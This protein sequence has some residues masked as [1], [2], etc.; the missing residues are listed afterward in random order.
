MTHKEV[1]LS[2]LDR[3]SEYNPDADLERI[4]AA[5]HFASKVHKDQKRLSGHPFVS[6]ALSVA[7]LVAELKLDEDSIIA[8]LLHDVLDEAEREVQLDEIEEKFGLDTA[9]L[10]DGVSNFRQA[11]RKFPVHEESVDQFRKFLLASVEDVRVLI[12]R[13]SDKIHN[14]RTLDALPKEDQERF[15]ERV[16]HLYSPLAEYAGLGAYKR[17]LDDKA[18]QVLYPEDYKW[19]VGELQADKEKRKQFVGKLKK[20]ISEELGE[21]KIKYEEIFGRVKGLWSTYQKIQRY[22][23]KG[24]IS[25]KD[26]SAVLDQIGITILVPDEGSCYAGLGVIHTRWEFLRGELDDYVANPKPNGYRAIQT[27][28]KWEKGLTAEVQIKTPEMHEHN[29]FGPASHIAYKVMGGKSISNYSYNW[30]KELVSWRDEGKH[31]HYKIKV[32]ED[33]VYCLTPKGDILQLPKGATPVDFAYQIHTDV[34]NSCCGAKANG[35]MV[36]LSY[37]LQNGDLVEILTDEKRGKPNRDWLDFVKTKEAK[38]RI[39]GALT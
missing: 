20:E 11:A 27:T 4:K 29:E 33:Y 23:K 24:K 28:I 25:E 34:G 7:H 13:L 39:R 18:F 8:A 14:A 37:R 12:I 35:E 1:F 38:K 32:F 31:K 10:V 19:L 9:L 30:V 2:L 15:A 5:Y 3:I 17:E 36:K 22:L 26:P 21:K 6:H 16:F